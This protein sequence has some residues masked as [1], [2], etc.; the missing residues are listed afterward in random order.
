MLSRVTGG[1]PLDLSRWVS[2]RSTRQAVRMGIRLKFLKQIPENL[3]TLIFQNLDFPWE[4][5]EHSPS[6][7]SKSLV[8]NPPWCSRNLPGRQWY[9]SWRTSRKKHRNAIDRKNAIEGC[10]VVKNQWVLCYFMFTIECWKKF[11]YEEI[12]SWYSQWVANDFN[13]FLLPLS[14][15]LHSHLCFYVGKS[16]LQL[17]V[18]SSL[19]QVRECKAEDSGSR[20]Q[21]KV[22]LALVQKTAVIHVPNARFARISQQSDEMLLKGVW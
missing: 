20:W 16:R 7:L 5:M 9:Q 15:W 3:V 12:I 22:S 6:Q 8:V 18:C 2:W 10:L 1:L 11:Q 21:S 13:V 14:L 17:A 4:K 19:I